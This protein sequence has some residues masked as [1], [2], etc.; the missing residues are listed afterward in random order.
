MKIKLI[1]NRAAFTLIELLVVVAIIAILA[2][3]LLPAL[4]R[5]KGKA[6]GA[7]CASNL[8]QVGLGLRLWSH[9]ASGNFP[10][11]V[12]VAD[13]G[14]QGSPEWIDH[15]R[16]CSNELVTPKVLLCPLQQGVTAAPNWS[17]AAGLDNVSFF[18]GITA[19]ESKPQTLLCGDANI[20]GG[21][22]GLNP[23]WNSFVG[24]SIDAA[25]DDTM[26]QRKGQLGLSDGSVQ[27]LSTPLLREQI[28]AAVATGSTNV[29]LS[30]PQGVL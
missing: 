29:V 14:S 12:A 4:A 30:K 25:W 24:S 2:G 9:D 20:L 27:L 5:A 18:A 10:W 6:R 23:Y 22:G 8:K 7:E 28:G 1:Q 11:A 13:G 21:G 16:T 15:F 26:H 17:W 19:E 3:L